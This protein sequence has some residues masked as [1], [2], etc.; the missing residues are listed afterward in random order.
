ME[1]V[2]GKDDK[3]LLKLNDG[4]IFYYSARPVEIT[5]FLGA[6]VAVLQQYFITDSMGNSYK[7]Y[8]TKEGNWYDMP[9]ENRGKNKAVLM[10]L[11]HGLNQAAGN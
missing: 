3:Q 8:R 11:K 1:N 7:L 10:S 2:S 4:E 6:A 5:N 9:D